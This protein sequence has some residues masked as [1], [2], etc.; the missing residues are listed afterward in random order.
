MR[1]IATGRLPLLRL[2][3]TL[4][5]D[6]EKGEEQAQG[7]VCVWA[8]DVSIFERFSSLPGS[9]LL[10][11]RSSRV[12]PAAQEENLWQTSA[13]IVQWEALQ[14]ILGAISTPRVPI[15]RLSL[16]DTSS[17]FAAIA[18]VPTRV[19]IG[20]CKRSRRLLS[21]EHE[22]SAF[23]G[24]LPNPGAARKVPAIVDVISPYHSLTAKKAFNLNSLH[25]SHSSS[26]F[27][28]M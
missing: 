25:R 10:A 8:F 6:P 13:V 4:L 24:N 1:T 17:H 27:A 3:S 21:L 18:V 23:S 16:R 12:A 7:L 15:P 20:F 26:R 19:P 5:I 14:P 11:A 22:R 28:M 9:K 2:F